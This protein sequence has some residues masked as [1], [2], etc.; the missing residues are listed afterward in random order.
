[1]NAIRLLPPEL[2]NQIAAGEVVERPASV[3][4]E[5]VENSLDAGATQVDVVLENGG[6]SL[7]QIRDNG[8]GVP[9]EELELAVTRHATS[10]IA[11]LDDLW[12]IA[13]FGFRG[14]ALPSIASVSRFRMESAHDGAEGAFIEVENGLIRH[15]GPSALQGGSLVSVRDL[16]I[17]VPARLKFLKT[18]ATEQKKAQNWLMRLALTRL[19]V[20]FTLQAGG[21]ELLRLR[22]E[23]SL[24]ERLGTIWP[25][26]VVEAL[27]PFD[28]ERHGIRA[29][30]LCADPRQSQPRADRLLFYV[31][32]RVV[33]DRLLLRAVREAY[34][35]R[36]IS[37]DYPQA[38]VFV[39]LPPDQVDVNVHPAKSEVRFIDEQAVF[40][41]VRLAITLALDR[42]QA[43]VG[44]ETNP[45][46]A[47]PD[48]SV[49]EPA[50]PGGQAAPAP[51]P[52]GFWG[53]ADME[54]ILPRPGASLVPSDTMEVAESMAP[55]W[56]STGEARPFDDPFPDFPPH[57]PS[58]TE[59]DG[60]SGVETS[61][62]PVQPHPPAMGGFPA[63]SASGRVQPDSPSGPSPAFARVGP[64][65]YLGQVANT[66]L[67]LREGENLVILDQHAAH[68]RVLMHRFETAGM[69]GRSRALLMPLTLRL[70]PAEA[71][72][73]RELWDELH[74]LGFSLRL[75]G[76]SL[77][78]S[79]V[80]DSFERAGAESLLKETLVGQREDFR[81]LW[82]TASCK[83]A[84][85]AGDALTVD[86]AVG[87]IAQWMRTPEKEHCPHGRPA[88]L[89]W[90]A[91][92][93]EKLFKRV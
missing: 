29:H 6:Q 10:K 92:D 46:F 20:G 75:D 68:E 25:P 38:V 16:F 36:L 85:K 53:E 32:G 88:V 13:S 66:Y 19:D 12:S 50:A 35:G 59:N 7:I 83:G 71:E 17:T 2:R 8:A 86:E 62:G 77:E 52:L 33:N 30:G 70:H 27:R 23:Q 78:V 44:Y 21:R 41:A 45:A 22:G 14:E 61:G 93:L 40:S 89:S 9:P 80:P 76:N 18:P 26:V 63:A 4:K 11:A 87:L 24:A 55:V 47:A 64:Y 43:G 54:R 82:I 74:A 28:H 51:R 60:G 37:R 90:S 84:I 81:S 1:M 34:K 79:A 56:N 42:P 39:D 5:L 49:P 65:I 67:V 31:N 73:A 57:A 91:G 48:S 72:R 15:S 3:V 58:Q 69:N